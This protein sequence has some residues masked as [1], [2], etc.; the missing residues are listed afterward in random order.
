MSIGGS[1]P[2]WLRFFNQEG[3][4]RAL[5][6]AFR[7]NLWNGTA[8]GRKRLSSY[9]QDFWRIAGSEQAA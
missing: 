2:H 7:A 3:K 6:M 9:L 8:P 5:E 1:A 4:E